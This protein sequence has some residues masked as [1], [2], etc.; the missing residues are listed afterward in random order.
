VQSRLEKDAD[1]CMHVPHGPQKLAVAAVQSSFP[2]TQPSG[3]AQSC[4]LPDIR[5]SPHAPEADLE[6]DFEELY[7]K[8]NV[9]LD[10][11]GGHRRKR[12]VKP[13][14]RTSSRAQ[15]ESHEDDSPP[16]MQLAGCL[17]KKNKVMTSIAVKID[18]QRSASTP[19]FD[20]IRE[21][22][23]K[24]N[25]LPDATW[26]S[27]RMRPKEYYLGVLEDDPWQRDETSSASDFLQRNSSSVQICKS[28]PEERLKAIEERA[29]EQEAREEKAQK[30]LIRNRTFQRQLRQKKDLANA[31][32]KVGR[33]VLGSGVLPVTPSILQQVQWLT[34]MA[35]A[36][37][38]QK[39]HSE[40]Q[41][42]KAFLKSSYVLQK[43]WRAR[44]QLVLPQRRLRALK[45]FWVTFVC[46][47]FAGI[48]LRRHR[49]RPS[50]S[51]LRRHC[52]LMRQRDVA[53]ICARFVGILL[54]RHRFRS[55][56]HA[57][58]CQNGTV[59]KCITEEW[60]LEFK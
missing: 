53:F 51:S 57:R 60:V 26:L 6:C 17:G 42:R 36:A 10:R 2:S 59:V 33:E 24:G 15:S 40:L 58:T 19:G 28:R 48:L 45:K 16:C 30:E 5:R 50:A 20:K 32:H 3:L 52:T 43:Y 7:A 56:V 55:P 47:R 8:I 1:R 9:S 21:C 18:A 39:F 44:R 31:C 13:L 34:V 38:M 12:F 49:L 37:S 23:F 11:N 27:R 25:K 14:K 4:S 41:R 29:I 35:T 22:T 54:H 46:V